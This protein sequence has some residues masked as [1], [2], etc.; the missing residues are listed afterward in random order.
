MY[1]RDVSRIRVVSGT[2]ASNW[3]GVLWSNILTVDSRK[4]IR[5]GC[6]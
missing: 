3:G 5:L 2:L 4:D 6:W 1:I